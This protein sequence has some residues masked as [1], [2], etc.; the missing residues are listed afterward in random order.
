[1]DIGILSSCSV[2]KGVDLA[3]IDAVLHSAAARE[4]PTYGAIRT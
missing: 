4:A 3:S 2:F 1:M